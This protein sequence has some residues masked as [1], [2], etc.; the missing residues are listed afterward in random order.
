MKTGKRDGQLIV[1]GQPGT[2]GYLDLIV[3]DGSTPLLGASGVGRVRGVERAQ[4]C[5]TEAGNGLRR[6]L[7]HLLVTFKGRSDLIEGLCAHLQ[8]EDAGM[9]EG[10]G[11]V[12]EH[13]VGKREGRGGGGGESDDTLAVRDEG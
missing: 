1:T 4:A 5:N 12:I 9:T 13:E 2:N 11:Q 7:A 10:G 3:C 6:E 8:V